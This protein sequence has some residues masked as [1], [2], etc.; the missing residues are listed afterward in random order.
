MINLFPEHILLLEILELHRVITLVQVALLMEIIMPILNQ[1]EQHQIK[2]KLLLYMIFLEEQELKL[3][4]NIII[5]VFM[6]LLMVLHQLLFGFIIQ[7]HN[8]GNRIGQLQI[9][10]ALGK[11]FQ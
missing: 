9:T 3:T 10:V 7:K 11:L 5:I 1:L 8:N 6:D 4:L 2:L